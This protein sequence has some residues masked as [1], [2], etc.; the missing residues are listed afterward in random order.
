MTP[1]VRR[2]ISRTAFTLA[3][4][5]LGFAV[6]TALAIDPWGIDW[7]LPIGGL[8]L[9]NLVLI[10]FWFRDDDEVQP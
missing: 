5:V 4:N 8:I 1:R 9:L 3:I 10:G 7:F 6:F 2:F